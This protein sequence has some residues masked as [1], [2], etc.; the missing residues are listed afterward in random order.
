MRASKNPKRFT[1]R[2]WSAAERA[3]LEDTLK[4]TRNPTKEER[5][6]LAVILGVPIRKVQVWFQNQRQREPAEY[7]LRVA[8]AAVLIADARPEWSADLV[9]QTADAWSRHGDRDVLRVATA[10]YIRDKAAVLEKNGCEHDAE[11]V[12]T[13]A[14][15][16]KVAD[17]VRN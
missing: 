3:L 6:S 11:A 5:S 15:L 10:A 14:L 13:Y 2:N 7:V 16:R 4:R 1:R 17:I 9:A 8:L 12:A